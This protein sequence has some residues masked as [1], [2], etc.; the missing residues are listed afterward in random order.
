MHRHACSSFRRPAPRSHH[1]AFLSR[2]HRAISAASSRGSSLA[3][4]WNGAF[5]GLISFQPA[6]ERLDGLRSRTA[7]DIIA[8][9]LNFGDI[10][11]AWQMMLIVSAVVI[12][13]AFLRERQ[14]R[15]HRQ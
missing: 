2:R 15:K 13:Y 3:G 7:A 12:V 4:K 10:S 11:S 1:S 14:L 6:S 9:I 5:C 8:A